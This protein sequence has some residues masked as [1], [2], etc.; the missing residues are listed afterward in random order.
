MNNLQIQIILNSVDKATAP[1]KAIAGRA[2]ALAEK[3]KHAQK[4][5]S[6]LDKTKNLAE[7]FKALRN[8][9]NSYAKALDTAKANSKQ[10]QSAVDSNT[11]KFNSITGKLGNATQQ[12]NKHKEEVI[13][14]KSVYNN[15]SI[16]LAKGMGFKSFNDARSSIARQIETQK[17]AIKD[18]NEQ[19]KKLKS[20]RKATEQ[21]V[22]STTKAL[23]GEKET[24][25]KINKEYK[26]HV[27]QLKKIQEQLHKAGFST[28]H[29]AQSEKQLSADIEKA[30]NKLAKHQRILALVER[31]Q[32]RFARI[33]AP[34]SSALNTG[35]NIAGVGVQASIG[36]Q[37][38]MQPIISMGRGVVGMAQ[39][40]GKF[41]QF[42]SVLEVTEGSSEK[43]KKSF[44]WVKKF[45]VDTPANLDEAMEAFVRL[46]AYGMDPTNGLLQTLGDTASAM[47]KP[48]MQAVEAIADAV[49]GENER[50]KE[51]G[52]KGS[53]IKGTKF[54]EYTY[55]DKNG[56]QQSARVDKNNRKQ[57]EET[58][59]RIWN[60]KYSGAMEKQSKTLLGIWAKLDD[61][62]ASFQ[63]K[64]MENGAFD[65]IKDKLQFL[66]KK[67]D[68][69]EQNG[70]LKKWAK[71]IGTVINEV[72]QGL[73]DFGKTVFE[74]VKWLAQF[75]SQNKGAI[76]TIVKFTAIAGVALMALAPLLFTLSLVAPVLQ[77]LGST[78]LWVGK[79]AITAILGIGK[80]MLA[81]PI[82]AVIALIIGALVYLWQ[83]W[84]E[85]KA[86][87][88]EGWNWLSE[89]AGQIWQNIVNSVTEKWNVLSAKVGEIT[90][91][92]GEFFR[93][94]WEGITDTAKN[95]GSNMMNKLK[96]G[97]LES[98]KNVQQAISST[99]D[100]IK[101]KLGFSKDT[102]KQ[103][104]QTKQ[105]IA[106]VTNNA[107]NNVPNINKWSGGYAGNGG[108]FEPKGIFH[109]GEYVMT[110]E[111]TSRLGVNTLNALNYGK[112]ALIAGRLG[113]S[114]A[115]AAP[116]QVDT[117]APIKWVIDN[118]PGAKIVERAKQSRNEETNK[119]IKSGSI[120]ERTLDALSDWNMYSSGG[121][122]GNG[123][124]YQPMGIVHGGEYVMTKEATSRLGV[125]TLNALNYGKQALIAGR[126]GLSVATAAPVQVDTRAPIKWV[127]DN[128]PGAKIV[129][130]AKQSRNE[131]TNKVIKSGS[132]TERTLDA[133]SDWN[134][135]SSGGYTGNGGKYQP[136][137][138][139]HGGEYVMTKEATS[140][141]GI[142]T[143]NALNYGKQAL[144]AGG[145]G[146]SV[147]TA[148]PVQVDTRAPISTRP[149][150]TQSSQPMSVNI[151]IHAAQ[152]MD[153]RAIAQQ[154]AKEIQRIE[155]QRQARA[156]SSMWDRA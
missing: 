130:R 87:L 7:K 78:F 15:M 104:E 131:E 135:Y 50:L 36:G 60:E 141:L 23:D 83:N 155:N 18:S 82:L 1:I 86:K 30:N 3:V 43:A 75:A 33:K 57:I 29:F 22:K 127:I 116:V 35:R 149:V 113:L 70:E 10:L 133:L 44:D 74:A 102:E 32:A 37:Q 97:V 38:I 147:A 79:V 134:M 125:N 126:L 90:N 119:V 39:V 62:W 4:A 112:Q 20:E 118:M 31:A 154:V 71:D 138:I 6:G 144:I 48:V 145:L 77:V 19:I 13:R 76:A 121:Y 25:N 156:R 110:K 42:Q 111:A 99:V 55:T 47:G 115:T 140:R 12:L 101:E 68:E 137:G 136:M 73:W 56:K 91:S 9:T 27:E 143:L 40:A 108:K 17:K 52:I 150:M 11:A 122:T 92:V 24:I 66:L 45:A 46:R 152:G 124:K 49:T 81:N 2:E 94:K 69:L 98:F 54:I 14:L 117:R 67:F 58:L 64:I 88:I 128:M 61:V 72:I 114:V 123:G 103:I 26:P 5:L 59:K 106:N 129:E 85:V 34:I 41:E 84:D 153:E 148:T 51:F 142:N 146:I 151:T 16:P 139:V 95:F 93:E 89:Q 8:E 28:K 96:D 21:A 109:G 80:A 53:A 132:I 65:W 120:T 63:M 100:W 105:N 107:E